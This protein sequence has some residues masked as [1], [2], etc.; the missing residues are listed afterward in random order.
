MTSNVRIRPTRVELD[1]EALRHNLAVARGW[2]GPTELVAVV[3]ANAYGH[4]AKELAPALES[5]GVK[6]FAVALIEEGIELRQAGVRSPIWVMGGAYEGGY[7][8]LL[9]NRLTPVIFR[10]EHL[11]GLS[12]AARSAGTQAPVHL[13]VDTGMGRIGV[14]LTEVEAFAEALKARP[15][16]VLEGFVSHFANADLAD[17]ALTQLQVRRFLD[18]LAVLKR[19]GFEPKHRHLS[20]SAGIMSLPEVRDGLKLNSVRPG[21]MLYGLSPSQS[22]SGSDRLRPVL[23]W[24]TAITH[25]KTVPAGTPVSYGSTWTAPR[26]SVIATLPVGYADGYSRAFS[27]RGRV[28][29]RGR[30]APIVGRV[31]MDMVMVD[32]TEIPGAAFGDEV[33]LIG[34]QGGEALGADELA[35]WM[36]SISY[37]VL[38]G[39][40]ARVPR[41]PMSV[42]EA[43]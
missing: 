43:R 26:T 10:P 23:S 7:D 21:L 28:L 37:E 25:L 42:V 2:C 16:L 24:K 18:A 17:V 8:A 22:F 12:A 31:C 13:K 6:V 30:R 32:V 29:V 39:V 27:N 11:E 35:G 1:L 33:V 15:E 14:Q 38:C 3:K 41:L 34:R 40:S 4:G 36:G 19:H 20:N 9:A 5:A